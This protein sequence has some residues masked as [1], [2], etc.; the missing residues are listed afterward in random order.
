MQL[1]LWMPTGMIHLCVAWQLQGLRK[2]WTKNSS[3]L[4]LIEILVNM[5][6]NASNLRQFFP[7]LLVVELGMIFPSPFSSLTCSFY[8][9]LLIILYSIE[10]MMENVREH[11]RGLSHKVGIIGKD[12]HNRRQNPPSQNMSFCLPCYDC[13]QSPHQTQW[14]ASK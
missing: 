14:D 3:N 12:K 5:Q 4:S 9:S 13:S 1:N 6:S 10:T 8:S 11:K 7:Y 2:D